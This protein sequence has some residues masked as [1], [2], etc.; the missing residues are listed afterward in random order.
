MSK[1]KNLFFKYKELILYLIFGTATTLVNWIF[2]V[3]FLFVFSLTVSNAIAWFLAVLFAYVVNKK[4]VF[5]SKYVSASQS[6]REISLFY[7]AR[8]LSG[9]IDILGLPL[10][11]YIGV[12]QQ[13]FGIEGAVAK[14]ILTVIGI[15][16]NYIFSKFIIFKKTK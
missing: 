4:Y 8:I 16:L 2:Y 10:L 3:L 7:A 6:I 14:A 15:I 5:E 1:I 9:A 11:I 12:D 13:V